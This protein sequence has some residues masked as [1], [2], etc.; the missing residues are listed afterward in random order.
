[1]VYPQ[2]AARECQERVEVPIV[3]HAD[4]GIELALQLRTDG[5]WWRVGW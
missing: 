3:E 4:D 2:V 5:D 1:V